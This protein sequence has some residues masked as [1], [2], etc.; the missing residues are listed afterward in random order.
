MANLQ[1][2]D[3]KRW[4][5]SGVGNFIKR[6]DGSKW[7]NALVRRWNGKSWETISQ[8]TYT[9]DFPVTW[10]RSYGGEGQY[11][12]D[13]LQSNN[14]LYQGRY[15]NPDIQWEGDWGIQKSMA[16]FNMAN[17]MK[18]LE[19][20]KIE[21]VEL[22]IHN[23]HW[24]YSAGGRLSVGAHNTTNP[25]AKF[26]ESRYNMAWADWRQRGG[27][28]WVTLPKFFAEDL[29]DGK[30]K[31]F[32]LHRATQDLFYYGY[33]YG[34]GHGSKSPKLRITYTK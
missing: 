7:V 31:G 2:W 9:K 15:G 5:N 14:R 6:W 23:M 13:W 27:D 33:F 28:R 24:W 30:A 26:S 11:K 19:G 12:G 22:Y 1:R 4:V 17:L 32:T 20:A 18:E 21:K 3:G 8:Q 34:A 25:P 10:T 29:R 16:G